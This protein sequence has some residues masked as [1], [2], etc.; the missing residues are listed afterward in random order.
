[1]TLTNK[2]ISLAGGAALPGSGKANKKYRAGTGVLEL[3][4]KDTWNP[5]FLMPG[6]MS[7]TKKQPFN[8]R[9]RSHKPH[10]KSGY[11]RSCRRLVTGQVFWRIFGQ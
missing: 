2:T 3:M 1:L 7:W 9:K 11:Y 6:K 10:N 4:P 8:R 5:L